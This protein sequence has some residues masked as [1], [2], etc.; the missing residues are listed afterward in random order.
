VN[1]IVGI[2][3]LG[4]LLLAFLID[5]ML[6]EPSAKVHPVVGMGKL[7]AAL[8]R[9]APRNS[10]P[11]ALLSGA[12]I[13]GLTVAAA[14]AM[15]ASADHWASRLPFV[16]RTLVRAY[17]LKP[18][19]AARALFTA[20]DQVRISLERGDLDQART[21]LQSLVSRETSTL[22]APL[23][24]AAAIES[25]A[26]NTSDSIVAPVLAYLVAGLPGAYVYRAA[27]TLDAMIGYRGR[28]EYL[29][30][31]AARLDDLLNLIP[32]RLTAGILILGAAVNG[33]QP[34]QALVIAW[35]DHAKTASPNAGWPM[36]AMAGALGVQLE[37]VGQYRLGDAFRPA[38]EGDLWRAERIVRTAI[39]I[40]LLA[41]IGGASLVA[42]ILSRG[43]PP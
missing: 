9:R 4:V 10:K 31:G 43:K 2:E 38:G 1:T 29:G 13:T 33:D 24:A 19:F 30:K 5:H 22:D 20:V 34:A 40:G 17:L 8:E 18:T 36:S 3:K 11:G 28:Y 39:A 6:G 41:V 14:G 35:R 25:L 42:T 23:V 21:A 32:A 15:S 7:V 16:L 27:N 26:E 12:V 37:K